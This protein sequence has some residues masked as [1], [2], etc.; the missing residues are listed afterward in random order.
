[1]LIS[2]I[3]PVYN[4]E[5]QLRM[6]CDSLLQQQV[7]GDYEILLIDDGSRDASGKICDEYA[8]QHPER[9][10][11]IHQPNR[12]A[13]AAR[14]TGIEHAQGE[15]LVFCDSDDWVDPNYLQQFLDAGMNGQTM[16]FSGIIQHREGKSDR[17]LIAPAM[18]VSGKSCIDAIIALRRCD[19]LGFSVNKMLVKRI[20]EENHLRFIEGLTLREDELFMMEYVRHITRIVINQQTPYHYRVLGSGLSKKRK[21]TEVILRVAS[22]LHDLFALVAPTAEGRYLGARIYLQQTCEAVAASKNREELRQAIQAARNARKNYLQAFNPAYLKD[23]RDRKV[24]QRSRWIFTL[25][26]LSAHLQRRLTRLIHI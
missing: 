18:D 8:A 9:I 11:V 19:M 6:C 13:G 5:N 2:V 15:Y 1:M 22:Q 14:N 23:R 10:R 4:V 16:P 25:G 20:I 3:V 26:S 17:Q 21:P 12:G 24:A 7:S